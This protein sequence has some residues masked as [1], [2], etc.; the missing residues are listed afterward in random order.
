MRLI[1]TIVFVAQLV[2]VS[3]PQEIY[4]PPQN[5]DEWQTLS[6]EDLGW[7]NSE[8]DELY[9]LLENNSTKSFMLLKDGKIV[10]EKYFG[11]YT[12]DSSWVWF[13]AGKSLTSM[14]VGIAQQEGYLDIDES[15]ST[16]LGNGWTS[17]SSEQ[18]RAI[19]IKHQLTMSTGLN[20][21]DMFCTDPECLTYKADP[22]T[23]WF[24]HNAP[25]S[26]LR[27]VVENATGKGLNIFTYE[28]I[29]NKT[30]MKGLWVPV[31]YNNFYFSTARDM[32]RYGL[33]ILNRGVWQIDSVLKDEEYFGAMTNSSQ[34]MNP[35][36]GYLWWLNGKESYIPPGVAD[37]FPGSIAPNAPD[38]LILAAGA[39]GQFIAISP[40]EKLIMIRQGTLRSQENVPIDFHNEI[41]GKINQLMCPTSSPSIESNKFR[42]F[43][44]P[45]TD[46]IRIE[47]SNQ[48]S[49][50][51]EIYS[52]NGNLVL[53]VK[54][55]RNIDIND[56]PAG[57]YFI[58]M[59]TGNNSEYQK[60]IIK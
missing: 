39:Q 36:Y 45:A 52:S 58:K 57:I 44:N 40:K 11:T 3:Y 15:S 50:Q 48:K 60:L 5:G 24:Y 38:D 12:K 49:F 19:K 51:L 14:L 18:E 7:C 43:P 2:T 56:L 29:N 32:A 1:L 6:L 8:V 9:Q 46:Y 37:S 42:V 28:A 33:L 27:N 35:S 16:Y 34:E 47:T 21:T 59:Q 10:L 22:G 26:L 55:N 31:G 17:M 20:E 30:G 54:N 25:Y 4:F 13:S 41:W 53:H 23:R